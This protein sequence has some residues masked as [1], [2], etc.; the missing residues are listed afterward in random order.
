MKGSR[1]LIAI[2]ENNGIKSKLSMHFGH[3]AFFAIYDT[4]IE[5]LKIV[6]NEIDHSNNLLTPVDQIMSLKPDIVFSLGMGQKALK[7]FNE[8]NIKIKT[9]NFKIVDEVIKNID[10]LKELKNGCLH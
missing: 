1:I 6:K 2:N 7:L 9:G 3:C 8:K 10:K 4:K 5:N